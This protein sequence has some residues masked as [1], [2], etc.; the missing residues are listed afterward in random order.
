MEEVKK[1]SGN[2]RVFQTL[3]RHLRRRAMSHNPYRIPVRLR[4]KARRE[5]DAMESTLP[6]FRKRKRR[7]AYF[8]KFHEKRQKDKKWLETHIWHAK[9]MKMITL[10]G[11]R[12]AAY[13]NDKGVRAIYRA[14]AHHCTLYDLSYYSC[15]QITG[16]QDSILSFLNMM[17]DPMVSTFEN[18][19]HITGAREGHCTLYRSKMYPLGLIAPVSFLWNRDSPSNKRQL[20]I[21]VHPAAAKECLDQLRSTSNHLTDGMMRFSSYVM[22][23]CSANGDDI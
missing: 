1:F 12:I 21:W 11:Y 6:N 16:P 20:W 8:F 18:Y 3:P 9:R 13:P 22:L 14:S 4:A 19:V 2:K 5:M 17:S 23:L 10:W 7:A 15:I